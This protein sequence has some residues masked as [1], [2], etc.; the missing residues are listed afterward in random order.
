MTATLSLKTEAL[1]REMAQLWNWDVEEL[2]NALLLEALETAKVDYEETCQAIA[3]GLAEV[4][5]GRTIPFEEVLAQR[6]VKWAAHANL[7]KRTGILC[8]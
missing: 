8:P 3:E 7:L 6:E 4:D 1:L 5:A 2:A